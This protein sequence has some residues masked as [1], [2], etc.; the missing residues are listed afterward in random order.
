LVTTNVGLFSIFWDARFGVLLQ[1]K[2]SN[3]KLTATKKESKI[4]IV[5]SISDEF[6]LTQGSN[7]KQLT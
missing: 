2:I 7:I 1:L 6:S 3:K 4:V 5:N